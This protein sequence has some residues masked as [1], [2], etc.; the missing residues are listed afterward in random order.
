[1]SIRTFRNKVLRYKFGL[2]GLRSMRGPRRLRRSLH[3]FAKSE[4]ER[5]SRL[6][7]TDAART[8]AAQDRRASSSAAKPGALSTVKNVARSLFNKA[9]GRKNGG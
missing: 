2:A 3:R 4:A 1:M 5:Q 9:F 6:G 7:L 8:R